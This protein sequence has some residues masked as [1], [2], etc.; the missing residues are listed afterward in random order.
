MIEARLREITKIAD[1]QFGF[2]PGKSTTEPI[3]AL[4]M[5]QEKY[6][7][8]NKELH[9]NFVDLEKVYDRVPRE[10]IWWGLRKKRVPEAN[11]MYEDCD[12]QVA[13]R[14]G[15][16][17]YFKVKVGLHQGSAIIPLPFIII[18]MDVL[19]A[20]EIDKEPPWAMLFADD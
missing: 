3:F 12:T 17:E 9:V 20:S 18:I 11:I 16:T 2:R 14:A 7:E 6:R 19:A 10:L 5:L 4:R 15:N 8:K 1:N 13:T